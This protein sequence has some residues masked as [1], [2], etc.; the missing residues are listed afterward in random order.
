MV[1]RHGMKRV[2]NAVANDKDSRVFFVRLERP[3]CVDNAYLV[4]AARA[5]PSV[6]GAVTERVAVN[7]SDKSHDRLR[8]VGE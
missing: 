6:K 7:R 4:P 1:L 2:H 5:R 8:I 3:F